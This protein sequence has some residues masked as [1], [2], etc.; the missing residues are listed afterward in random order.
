MRH[1]QQEGRAADV[2]GIFQHIR[3][4]FAKNLLIHL[5]D[6]V[7]TE[8]SLAREFHIAAQKGIQPGARHL[9]DDIRHNGDIDQR[10]EQRLI[11]HAQRDA[12]DPRRVIG[13][14]LQ[15]HGDVGGGDDGAQIVRGGLLRGNHGQAFVFDLVAQIVDA[16]VVVD[17]LLGQR[18]VALFQ[19]DDRAVDGR[20]DHAAQAQNVVS[21]HR[22]FAIEGAAN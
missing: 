7:V 13:H 14:A 4:Q 18:A 9:F 21:D 16:S 20:F 5:I 1:P 11:Q 15:L 19:R 17:D 3:Q 10:F 12:R 22:L 2:L 8:D 6:F